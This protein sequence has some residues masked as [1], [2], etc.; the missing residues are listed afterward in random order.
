MPKLPL[1][2][3]VA[4]LKL[5]TKGGLTAKE[6]AQKG[7]NTLGMGITQDTL[8]GGRIN[9]KVSRILCAILISMLLAADRCT[10]WRASLLLSLLWLLLLLKG[11]GPWK[12][13]GDWCAISFSL[14]IVSI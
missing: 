11:N 13:I 2:F 1:G 6:Q 3:C 5:A 7:K 9:M 12:F 14:G 8:W 10:E 4:S